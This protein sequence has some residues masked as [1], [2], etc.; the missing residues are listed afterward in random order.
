MI[1]ICYTHVTTDVQRKTK[2]I[3]VRRKSIKEEVSSKV[4]WERSASLRY[5]YQNHWWT[6]TF[7]TLLLTRIRHGSGIDKLNRVGPDKIVNTDDGLAWYYFKR[8]R[9][10]EFF[11]RHVLKR[12]DWNIQ[13][14]SRA[15]KRHIIQVYNIHSIYCIEIMV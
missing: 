8:C 13:N 6:N 1:A 11:S 9:G 14:V 7:F 4:L 2:R 3:I 5:I 10:D 15:K 12:R